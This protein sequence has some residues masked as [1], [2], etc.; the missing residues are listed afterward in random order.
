MR[1]GGRH[2]DP[3][4]AGAVE[5]RPRDRMF[6]AGFGGGRHGHHLVGRR[7]RRRRDVRQRHHAV[8]DR[9]G[10]VEQRDV[11]PLRAFEDLGAF[12]QHPQLGGAARARHDGHRGRETER[13]RTGDQQYR[14]GMEHRVAG[15]RPGERDPP[16]GCEAR[17]DEHGGNEDRRD[18][19]GE[20]LHGR[21]RALRPFQRSDDACERGVGP[22]RGDEHH[23][24]AVAV[25]RCTHDIVAGPHLDRHRFPRQQRQI[26]PRSTRLHD[27]VGR[28][29]LPRTDQHEVA[30]N[31]TVDRGGRL[32]ARIEDGGGLRASFEQHAGGVAGAG[33]SRGLEHLADQ[34]QR[35]DHGRGVEVERVAAGQDRV[36]AVD[37]GRAGP[38]RDQGVHRAP[39]MARGDARPTGRTATPRT[40]RPRSSAPRRGSGSTR[41]RARRRST[42]APAGCR[43]PRRSAG[44]GTNELPRRDPG[45]RRAARPRTPPGAPPSNN[46]SG[47]PAF[48]F[49]V[50]VRVARL[51]AGLRDPVDRTQGALDRGDARGARHALDVQRDLTLVGVGRHARHFPANRPTAAMSS[52]TFSSP[53][54]C[55]MLSRTQWRT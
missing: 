16:Q 7:G 20:L 35:D 31:H 38:H 37:V 12:E 6:G 5:D 43:P 23:Q 18:A 33:P 11:H 50:A 28:D 46:A 14:H 4:I 10:L 55:S 49:T 1:R 54:P 40:P 32:A 3:S 51:T 13:A 2:V 34:D 15:C 45:S 53:V 9:P 36:H 29:L 30:R 25:D 47:S 44:F 21:L 48:P 26:H 42:T 17:E 39:P 52:S 19:V 24:P 27:P 8:G 41:D 22:H